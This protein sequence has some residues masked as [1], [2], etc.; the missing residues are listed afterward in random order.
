MFMPIEEAEVMKC[1][2]TNYPAIVTVYDPAL[3]GVNCD[4]DCST[5]ATGPLEGFMY[6]QYAAC[7]ESLLGWYVSFPMLGMQVRCMDTGGAIKAFWSPRDGQCVLPFDVLWPLT[8]ED[9][10][11][12]NWWYIE[13]WEVLRGE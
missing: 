11:Y 4:E 6:T 8:E 9:P 3:G 2:G 7:D 1:V 10:P 5:L 12:W 13:T